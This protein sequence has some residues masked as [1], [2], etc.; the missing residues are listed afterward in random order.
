VAEPYPSSARDRWR[1]GARFVIRTGHRALAES[2]Y[3]LIAPV[4]T[5]AS[6]LGALAGRPGARLGPRRW[7]AVAYALLA[8]P[9]AMVT[10]AVTAL[11]WFAGLAAATSVVRNPLTPRAVEGTAL[12]LVV[13]CVL[14]LVTRLCVAALASLG[15]GLLASAAAVYRQVGRPGTAPGGAASLHRRPGPPGP[16]AGTAAAV[17]ADAAALRR[18]ERDIHDGPQQRLVRLAMDLGRAQ[19]HL[20]SRPEAA[21]A[22]LA[23]AIAQTRETLD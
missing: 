21:Q 9:V 17:T 12:G 23:D 10:W 22:V 16:A 15:P 19:H 1:P 18:L 11:W 2:L 7:P 20:A 3:L 13:L 8:I 4:T 6:L 5:T 14:P